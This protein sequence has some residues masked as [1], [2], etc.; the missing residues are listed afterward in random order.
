MKIKQTLGNFI[1][2]QFKNPPEDPLSTESEF[3]AIMLL[4]FFTV[5]VIF[6]A[7]DL[8]E[9]IPEGMFR[10]FKNATYPLF[11]YNGLLLLFHKKIN[12]VLH[13]FPLLLTIDMAASI[14]LLLIGGG[15]RNSYFIYSFSTIIIFTL[16]INKKGAWIS[17]ILL[18]IASLIKEP[19][20]EG[21]ALISFNFSNMDMRMG[22]A[23]AYVVAGIIIGYF[24]YLIDKINRLSGERIAEAEKKAAIEQKMKLALD[25]HDNIKSKINA[26]IL[27]YNPLLKQ[28]FEEKPEKQE[29]LLRLWNW[30]YYLQKETMRFFLSLKSGYII[31]ESSFD[32]A[33]LVRDEIMIFKETTKF[34]W[35]LE[36]ED[37][38]VLLPFAMKQSVHQFVSECF[39]NAWK[40]SGVR[41]GTVQI[42]KENCKVIL[43]ISEN[44]KGFRL[45]DEMLS[46]YSGIHSLHARAYEF[47]GDLEI[48]TAP[49]QGCK[50]TLC[51]PVPGE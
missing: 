32:L 25:L 7:V 37:D 26:I 17:S 2:S 43:V 38:E 48:E 28:L 27:T 11:V 20:P 16:V 34:L 19:S 18:I 36:N 12:K 13:K 31:D 47:D 1:T 35:H 39:L 3:R 4:R 51:I 9:S 6:F 21:T 33:G 46:G 14:G 41:K 42:R 44:G 15:W 49:G 40:H 24:R 29:E 8:R 10:L 50:M 23:L 5:I 30:L 22:A 45:T